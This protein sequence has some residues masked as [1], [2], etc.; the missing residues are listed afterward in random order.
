MGFKLFMGSQIGGLNIDDDEALTEGLKAVAD[1]KVPV[2]VHAEDKALLSLNEEKLKNAKKTSV[3]AFQEAHSEAVEVKAIER[4]L[5]V[6]AST[7]VR[8]HFCHVSTE[9]GLNAIAG[10]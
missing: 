6:S 8:L 5:K 9:G 4:L 2:A 10:S 3:A 7:G 1:L